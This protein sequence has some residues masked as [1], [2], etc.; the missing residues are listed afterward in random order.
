MAFPQL[1]GSDQNAPQRRGGA[2]RAALLGAVGDGGP[3]RRAGGQ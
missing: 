1:P 2:L 3:G